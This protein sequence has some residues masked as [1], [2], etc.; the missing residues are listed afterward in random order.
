MDYTSLGFSPLG[1]KTIVSPIKQSPQEI[2]NSLQYGDILARSIY[3]GLGDAVFRATEDGM[4]LGNEVMA[5]AP[6][7]V[8]MSGNANLT[9]ATLTSA[10][11]TGTIAPTADV[12]MGTYSITN[13]TGVAATTFTGALTGNASTATTATN[14]SGGSV[15]ATTGIFSGN[16]SGAK[17]SFSNTITEYWLAPLQ[18]GHIWSLSATYIDVSNSIN[19]INF[20]DIANWTVYFEVVGFTDAGTSYFRLYNQTDGAEITGSEVSTTSTSGV[21]LRS[22]AITKP[23]GSKD[24]RV[25]Y[26]IVGGNGTTQYVNAVMSK[27]IVRYI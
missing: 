1:I 8:D 24:I 12:N 22:G 21:R 25:Q 6:F 23:S 26:K 27:L 10:T 20:D 11:I 2:R 16:V 15:S 3:I 18:H 4:W 5:S 14:V 17:G 9:S 19:Y 13:A 7:R